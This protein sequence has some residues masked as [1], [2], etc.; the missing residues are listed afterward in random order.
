MLLGN[1]GGLKTFAIVSAFL[2][3]TNRR[4]EKRGSVFLCHGQ[5]GDFAVKA[6]ELL[7]DDFRD[8]AAASSH[9]I[10]PSVRKVF[11][12]FHQTLSFARGRHERFHDAGEANFARMCFQLFKTFGIEIFCGFQS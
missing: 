10:F 3:V 4:T 11:R 8:V 5:E 1:V 12:T 7:N 2:H 6:N 9:R